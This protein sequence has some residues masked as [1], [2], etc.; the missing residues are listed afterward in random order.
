VAGA[1][2][3]NPA[4]AGLYGSILPAAWSFVLALRARGL[5]SAWTTM[6]L[7]REREVAELLGIPAEV[8]QVAL[9]PVAYY[10]GDTF[11]PAAR[12]PPETVT[13]WDGWTGR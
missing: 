5:G 4:A 12:P 1:D 8:T 11:S 3:L 2:P 6:H 13:H 10:T 9:L 7:S